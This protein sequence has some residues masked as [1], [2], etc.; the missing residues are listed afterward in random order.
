MDC[1]QLPAAYR[2]RSADSDDDAKQKSDQVKRFKAA[3]GSVA[4]PPAPALMIDYDTTKIM[5]KTSKTPAGAKWLWKFVSRLDVNPDGTFRITGD[6]YQ[7]FY[8]KKI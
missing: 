7:G 1:S 8:I 3:D 2:K 4:M 5:G 6:K